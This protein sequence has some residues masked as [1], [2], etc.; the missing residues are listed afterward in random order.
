MTSI[1][2]YVDLAGTAL[3]AGRLHTSL[4]RGRVSS[5]F[6][7]DAAFL[8]DGSAYA[9]DPALPLT[10]GAWPVRGSLPG[11]FL[12]AA[13]DR[14]GRNL[15]SRRARAAAA[16]EGRPAPQLDDRD[17]LLGVSDLTRQGAL[18]FRTPDDE[19]F[20]HPS[21]DV[22]ALIQLPRLLRASETVVRD[23][24]RDLAAVKALLDAGTGSLGGARP[25]ASVR[26]GAELAI[27]KFPHQDDSWDVMAWEKTALDLAA[28]AGVTVAASEL[29]EIEGRSVLVVRRFDRAGEERVGYISAMTLVQGADGDARDYLEVADAMTTVSDRTADDLAQL[30]RRIAFSAAI[31]NTDDHLRNLGY[32][33]HRAGWR[34]SPAFDLNPNP[35]IAARRVTSIAGRSEL[36]T[37]RAGLLQAA[38]DFGLTED[39]A[40]RILVE[41]IDAVRGWRQTARANRI[42]LSEIETFTPVFESAL[43]SLAA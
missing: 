39:A 34:L 18:R 7:Y 15:I 17:F 6:T 42:A 28:S 19:A 16:A 21:P 33:R 24:D 27:A 32:V 36:G 1:D 5:T 25:K 10:R 29:L 23:G 35:N 14:W 11:S 12:D 30:W 4:R 40:R 3:P 43:T 20:Q 9:I 41:V 31:H 38:P 2:A 22:P 37:E 8:A 26:D 13:P